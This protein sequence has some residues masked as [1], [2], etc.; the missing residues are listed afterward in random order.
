MTTKEHAIHK[1]GWPSL[2]RIRSDSYA[3]HVCDCPSYRVKP[4][5]FLDM[6]VSSSIR[7]SITM[8]YFIVN[9]TLE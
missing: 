9:D 7:K 4:T 6:F 8:R 5:I 1:M 3:S 2:L